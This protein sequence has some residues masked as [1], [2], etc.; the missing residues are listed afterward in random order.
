MTR[1]Q[2]PHDRRLELALGFPN[3]LTALVFG[4]AVY[5]GAVTRL[6]GS[7]PSIPLSGLIL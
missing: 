7:D 4:A 5:S 1:P 6:T 3:E 2:P